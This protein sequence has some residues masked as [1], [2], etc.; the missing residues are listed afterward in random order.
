[1]G[2]DWRNDLRRCACGTLN[3]LAV[4]PRRCYDCGTRWTEA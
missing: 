2:R 4:N 3:N 1:M